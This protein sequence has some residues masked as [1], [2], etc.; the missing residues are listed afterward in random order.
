[1]AQKLPKLQI[2]GLLLLTVVLVVGLA[3]IALYISI[4]GGSVSIPM[5]LWGLEICRRYKGKPGQWT[6]Y[7]IKHRRFF[8]RSIGPNLH[9]RDYEH[10]ATMDYPLLPAGVDMYRR[11]QRS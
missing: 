1:M 6:T 4:A 7:L 2:A 5:G 9:D 10:I 8:R 11:S 3:P